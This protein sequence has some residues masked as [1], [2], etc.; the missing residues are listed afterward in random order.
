MPRFPDYRAE[1]GLNPGS[2]PQ[3]R[4]GAEAIGQGLQALGSGLNAAAEGLAAYQAK[5]ARENAFD[6]EV[7][8]NQRNRERQAEFEA[9][10]RTMPPGGSG[11]AAQYMQTTQKSDSALLAKTSPGNRAAFAARL[12]GQR[13]IDVEKAALYE[14]QYRA[15][16][17]AR[18]LEASRAEAEQAITRNPAA[19][20]D[21]QRRYFE[22]I[23]RS[24]LPLAQKS[25][26]KQTGRQGFA[27]T[28]WN[29]RYG[30]DPEAGAAAFG[31]APVPRGRFQTRLVSGGQTDIEGLSSATKALLDGMVAA[32]VVP[33]L[34][35][36]SGRRD[37]ATNA[38]AGGARG[39]QHLAG[40][41]LDI[42][43]T[44]K[45]DAEKAAI[46]AA[47]V[48]GG[49]RGIGLYA[50]GRSLHVDTR[51]APTV[52]GLDA[53]DAYRGLKKPD[54][55]PDIEATLARAPAWA[56]P[57]LEKLY[58]EPAGTLPLPAFGETPVDA[59]PGALDYFGLVRRH[60]S[61]G[62]DQAASRGPDGQTIAVGRYQFTAGTWAA[63]A[64]KH[65][66]LEL[67]ADGSSDPRQ[68][69]KAMRALTADNQAAL[70]QAGLPITGANTYMAHFLGAAGA[71]KFLQA[72]EENPDRSAAELFPAAAASNKGVFY[73]HN[74]GGARSLAEVYRRQT[75][76]FGADAGQPVYSA[77]PGYADAPADPAFADISPRDQDR[78]LDQATTR[79]REGESLSRGALESGVRDATR[80]LTTIGRHD[81]PL[82]GIADFTKAYGPQTGA[83]RYA[84]FQRV[85]GLGADIDAIQAMTP[86]EQTAWLA[87]FAPQGN[88]P[89]PEG[90]R[91]RYARAE[92]AIALNRAFRSKD[93][94]AYVRALNPRI[95]QLWT[96]AGTSPER[97][98]T[99]LSATN[100][101]MDRLGM[102]VEERRLMP[103]A[104]V[105]QALAAFGDTGKPMA[106]RLAPLRA[107]IVA[108]AD[109]K[110]QQA[111]FGQMVAAGLPPMLEYAA[112]AYA[113]GDAALAD[114]FATA[115]LG[116]PDANGRATGG[117]DDASFA[118]PVAAA[119]TAAGPAPMR[120]LSGPAIDLGPA[121]A[122]AFGSSLAGNERT[123][124]AETVRARMIDSAMRNNGGDR[125][126]AIAQTDRDLASL[127]G[128]GWVP[129]MYM[130]AP[131]AG[132]G[133]QLAFQ[134]T[135]NNPA[136]PGATKNDGASN[137]GKGLGAGLP[138]VI[139]EKISND[140]WPQP[141]GGSENYPGTS[142]RKS[143]HV[144]VDPLG[145]V[146]V[147][148]AITRLF[149]DGQK[150]FAPDLPAEFRERSLSIEIGNVNSAIQDAR[151]QLMRA[152]R[153][154]D[155]QPYYTATSWDGLSYDV[156]FAPSKEADDTVTAIRPRGRLT[157]WAQQ[158][159][160]QKDPMPGAWWGT[161]PESLPKPAPSSS[162]GTSE[163]GSKQDTR[164]S[165]T[166]DTEVSPAD[167][168]NPTTNTGQG[169]KRKPPRGD[170][171]LAPP[172]DEP[173]QPASRLTSRIE[174]SSYATKLAKSL[175]QQARKDVDNILGQYAKGNQNPGIGS[176]PIG[177]RFTELRGKN[178]G[179]A[180]IARTGR[181]EYDIVGTFQAHVRGD[182]QNSATI[183][184][185]IADYLARRA[186]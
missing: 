152:E 16:Y 42:D 185:L 147:P 50:G 120:S 102:P 8:F 98:K 35:V 138:S 9:A 89:D 173:D 184:R 118:S 170:G 169:G 135:T 125:L 174:E 109:A 77:G 175:S 40:N 15:G 18:E 91:D 24:G 85:V 131:V 163:G 132:A 79:R 113:R 52:W 146:L 17:E 181:N 3:V 130:H 69:E 114:R 70:A 164:N 87:R 180:I 88:G 12:S 166:P 103:K 23:D 122:Q 41:A 31:R 36:K 81:G 155:P 13:D 43:I 45:S 75:A 92:Q 63:L 161:P 108:G 136:F 104:M 10:T 106:Q 14:Q 38:A 183:K 22:Q 33:E 176:K 145:K 27:A 73:D 117:A 19:R 59:S 48:A 119:N 39:S 124:R 7:R 47:A 11:F 61:G 93:P 158:A 112:I 133:T 84:D 150:D 148:P 165:S 26:L 6:D 80:D 96:E 72:L 153:Q 105:D 95:D 82:P 29:A 116:S 94:N 58:G 2:T 67:S 111:I 57:T 143:Y 182:T 62:N 142:I 86:A 137:I 78:L 151:F 49:A 66:G 83:R 1:I 177:S 167:A 20:A 99:A 159:I 110:A 172:P 107:A 123:S 128:D 144:S 115:A 30:E 28:D 179:R 55:T 157:N 60:E 126:A 121:S 54:G 140:I 25:A 51:Q 34:K 90:A 139:S 162:I 32:G 186:K 65:P 56:R 156:A 21:E 160:G 178:G 68:Q 149:L 171:E 64:Q 74:S 53:A 37:E 46:L 76:M 168:Q 4:T 44:G 97:L 71:V 100:A 141:E 127:Q 134:N 5:T 129:G 101:A 154:G